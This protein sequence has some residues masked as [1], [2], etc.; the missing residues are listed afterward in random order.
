MTPSEAANY[1]L[2]LEESLKLLGGKS[3]NKPTIRVM[4][5]IQDYTSHAVCF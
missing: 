2:E 5:L 1:V 4:F 3:L